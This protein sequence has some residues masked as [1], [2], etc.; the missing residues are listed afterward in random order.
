MTTHDDL[1]GTWKHRSGPRIEVRC[2]D[3]QWRTYSYMTGRAKK[4]AAVHE[5]DSPDQVR[6]V[7]GK[8]E[9]QGFTRLVDEPA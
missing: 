4:P 1:I 8:L 9:Q 3:G 6:A 7:I 5:F 2:E